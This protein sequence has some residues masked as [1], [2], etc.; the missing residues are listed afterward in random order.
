MAPTIEKLS[1]LPLLAQLGGDTLRA[2][3]PHVREDRYLAGQ[4]VSL[5]G[6]VCQAV[7]FVVRGLVRVRQISMEGR[8]HVLAYLGPGGCFGLAA[9]A[10][11]GVNLAT[12]D[13]LVKSVLYII[14]SPH[15][16]EL[17]RQHPDLSLAVAR[18]LAS[19]VRQLSDTVKE[20][21]FH[22][23]RARLARF[24][25]GHA[26]DGPPERRWTQEMIA[27]QIGTVRE[28]VGRVLRA[29]ADEGLIRRERGR[30]VVIDREG[31]GRE[32]KTE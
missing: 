7:S 19:E 32:A 27:S 14:P 29:L 17:L 23:V 1:V 26:E 3:A 20:L 21:A 28:V 2:I 10:N 31:L 24:L 30:I 6:D 4:M 12:V 25:L 11:G 15:F 16:D 8:E 13:S 9:A 18:S 22:T 5:E